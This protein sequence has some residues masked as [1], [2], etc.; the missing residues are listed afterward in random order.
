MTIYVH[1]LESSWLWVRVSPEAAI[2][3]FDEITA[4]GDLCCVALSFWCTCCV[5]LPCLSKH[6]MGDYKVICYDTSTHC[7]VLMYILGKNAT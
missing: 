5:A 4:L 1:Y 7:F 3:F 6:L 2:I